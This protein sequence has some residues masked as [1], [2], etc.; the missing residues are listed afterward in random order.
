MR[1]VLLLMALVFA[2]WAMPALAQPRDEKSKVGVL[3]QLDLTEN[4]RQR[5]QREP[6]WPAQALNHEDLYQ[7]FITCDPTKKEEALRTLKVEVSGDVVAVVGVVQVTVK[8]PNGQIND[9]VRN[10]SCY[11]RPVREGKGIVKFTPVG[12][13]GKDRP[14]QEYFILVL[15]PEPK[16]K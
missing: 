10:I 6:P 4:L 12:E 15:K 16:N 3:V 14:T 7:F 13:D 9:F 8:Q 5:P 1:G 11:I 2:Q